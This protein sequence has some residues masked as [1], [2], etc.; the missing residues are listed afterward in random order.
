MI[1]NPNVC[2]TGD[3][4]ESINGINMTNADHRDAV[5]IVKESKRTL[6]IVSYNT[7]TKQKSS[8]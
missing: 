2:R 4:L 3:V 1:K 5:R 8:D 7:I 6:S